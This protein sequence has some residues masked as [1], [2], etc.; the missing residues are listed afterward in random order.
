M[1]VAYDHQIFAMQRHG[2]ISRYFA[3]LIEK[4]S[5]K[6]G[7]QITVVAPVHINNYLRRP[8][9]HGRVR[10]GYIPFEFRGEA[11]VSRALNNALLPLAWWGRGFDI[12]HETYYSS[13]A[14]GRSKIRVVTI[15]D[16]IHE[17]YPS[18]FPDAAQVSRAKRDA[19]RRADHVICI[20]ETTRRDACEILGL[21][22]EGCS[23]IHLGC[24]L[25]AE[26]T[27]YRNR[28]SIVPCVLYVGHRGGYKNFEVVLKAFASS[29]LV[30]RGIDLIA[31]GGPRFTA[32]ERIVIGHL[33]IEGRVRQI[34]GDDAMLRAYYRAAMALVY[35]S[36][37]EGFGIPPLEAMMNG[38]PVICSTAPSIKEI[39]GGAAAYFDP[40]DE[41]E[42]RLLFERVLD[43]DEYSKQLRA[44]GAE[45]VAKFSWA[46]C[47]SETCELY[48]RLLG[49]GSFV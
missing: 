26:A 2:G 7:I 29:T 25:G 24:S 34:S 31:F 22:S 32:D 46:K 1:K 35:P 9:I 15:Y 28:V 16:M 38:C 27:E 6:P 48:R 14:K 20:S 3:E 49:R 13:T 45:R 47:A 8:T 23:V 36:R 21:R 11:R 43:D 39:V 40:D 41:G 19:V 12:V 5:V 4:L 33:G 44:R 17:R 42:L 37:Y 18:E 30:R 10:G